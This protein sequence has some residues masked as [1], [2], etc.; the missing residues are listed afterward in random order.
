MILTYPKIEEILGF[1]LPA[2]AYNYPHSYWANTETHS[3]SS[4]WMAVE[5]KARVDVEKKTVTF[6]KI[7][8]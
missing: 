1:S 4:S 8:I 6:E 7:V 3:Y 5:Y 2:T